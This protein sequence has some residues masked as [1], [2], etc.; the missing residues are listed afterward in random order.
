MNLFFQN[1]ALERAVKVLGGV[2]DGQMPAGD[3]YSSTCEKA[4]LTSAY[5]CCVLP[6]KT[7]LLL[8][9]IGTSSSHRADCCTYVTKSW[10]VQ[11]THW[12]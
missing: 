9:S 1:A 3:E 7:L 6:M 4:L 2:K 8:L 10:A 12:L 5:F 11:A